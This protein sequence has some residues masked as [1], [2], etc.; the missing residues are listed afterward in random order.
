MTD[1]ASPQNRLHV[2]D[3]VPVCA[4]PAR[5]PPIALGTLH[6]PSLWLLI[7]GCLAGVLATGVLDYATGPALS[8][9]IFY[10]IPVA[11]CAWWGGFAHGIL[12]ALAGAVAWNLV[13]GLENPWMTA[14]IGLWNG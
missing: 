4:L 8:L 12:L 2:A 3:G 14:P 10:L 5:Q 6:G 11:V 9:S 1:L 13:D 7:A